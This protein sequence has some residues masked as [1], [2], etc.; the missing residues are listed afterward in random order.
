[1]P[2]LRLETDMDNAEIA[3]RLERLGLLMT[4]RGEDGFR[5]GAYRNAAETISGMTQ[6]VADIARREGAKGLMQLPGIGR[7]ISAKILELVAR[8]SFETW[9]RVTAE[10]P[11]TTLDLLEVDGIGIKT[12]AMLHQRFK[13]SSIDDLREFVEGG[14]M[15]LVDGVNEKL[16]GRIRSYLKR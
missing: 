7:A 5:V 11:E 16:E 10:T 2:S 8:G 9:D 4:L 6:P 14:G 3:R 15:E 13:I 1:M 12:A